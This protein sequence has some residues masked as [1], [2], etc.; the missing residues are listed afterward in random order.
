MQSA[1]KYIVNV[2]MCL[3]VRQ[4]I[5]GT[6]HMLPIDLS[7]TNGNIQNGSLSVQYSSM[8]DEYESATSQE[9]DCNAITANLT[10]VRENPP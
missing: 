10:F 5:S 2:R 8:D 3:S 6:Q 7:Q 9:D 4:C 1:D